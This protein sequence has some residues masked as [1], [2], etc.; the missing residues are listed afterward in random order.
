M[1]ITYAN[2]PSA[3]LLARTTEV[4]DASWDGGCNAPGLNAPGIG[5]NV[6][7]GAIVGT[8]AQFTLKDQKDAVRVPQN[9]GGISYAPEPIRTG[10]NDAGGGGDVTATGTANLQTLAAGWVETAV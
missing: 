5:I 9:S 4:P 7:G 6:G 10:T 8:P 2:I 1:A 3:L